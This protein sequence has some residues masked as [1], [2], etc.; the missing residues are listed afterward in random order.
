MNSTCPQCGAGLW[1]ETP[2]GRRLYHC[3]T[4]IG[5]D[6]T[7]ES[8]G[9]LRAQLAAAKAIVDKLPNLVGAV[10][11]WRELTP[12]WY[13]AN[14]DCGNWL[15]CE[16]ECPLRQLRELTGCVPQEDGGID[17]QPIGIAAVAALETTP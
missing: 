12:C 10:C 3:G 7:D 4:R 13:D 2:D 11:E 8:A 5:T 1:G 14:G 17:K 15:N 6:G 9:C 16:P